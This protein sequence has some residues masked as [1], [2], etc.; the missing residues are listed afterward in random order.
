MPPEQLWK[1]FQG[2]CEFD[3]DHD[4]YWPALTKLCEE[5]RLEQKARW[6]KAGKNYGEHEAYIRGAT[7]I[8]SAFPA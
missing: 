5:R 6:E 8:P 4:T 7:D 1:E 2:D 3:Y